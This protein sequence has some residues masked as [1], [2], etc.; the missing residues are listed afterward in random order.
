MARNI[1]TALVRAF[2]AVAETGGMTQAATLLNVTQAAVSQRIKRLEDLFEQPLF[3]RSSR[4]LTL[5]PAGERLIGSAHRLLALNDEV[6]GMMTSPEFEGEVRLGVPDDLIGPFIPH[7]LRSFSQAWPKVNVSLVSKTSPVLRTMLANG[8]IDLTLTTEMDG[9]PGSETLMTDRLVFVGPRGGSAHTRDV[10]PIAMGA[11]TCAFRAATLRALT[12]F[13]R[14][15][16]IVCD[17]L[18]S[19]EITMATVR[20][21]MG[22]MAILTCTVPEDFEILCETDGVPSL[23]GFRINLYLPLDGANE[24]AHEMANHIRQMVAL[25][26]PRAA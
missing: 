13:G 10:L 12:D 20:A 8:E 17:D 6:W 5:T 26:F 2:V 4:G 1:D 15:W 18:Q 21:D 11:R 19:T 22:V 25:R 16:R 14:P 24:V 23:P 9:G 7:V 3:E